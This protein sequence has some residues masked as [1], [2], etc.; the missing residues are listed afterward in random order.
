MTAKEELKQYKSR[1]KDVDRTL[2]E[3][4]MFMERATKINAVVS[5]MTS[6]TNMP[7]D[8]VGDNA[9]KMAE[10][11]KEYWQRWYA[12][13]QERIRLVDEINKV[14]GVLGDILYDLYIVG[15]SMEDTAN[16]VHFS[17][18]YTVTLHGIAL[19]AFE[20][21]DEDANNES[22]KGCVT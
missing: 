15:L 22:S 10:L 5:E 18:D 3:Y 7:S 16:D 4:E 21:R 17:Y 11:S 13:E 1:V 14:G 12:A 2:E 19:Q 9:T 8:K 20:R 6:R